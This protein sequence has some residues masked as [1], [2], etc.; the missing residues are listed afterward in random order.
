MQR[1][2]IESHEKHDG[3]WIETDPEGE[4][5]R[6]DEAI[7]FLNGAI[8]LLEAAKGSLPSD[9]IV[10]LRIREFLDVEAR[11]CR[12]IGSALRWA[13]EGLRMS[14]ETFYVVE[15]LRNDW[16][17]SEKTG[18]RVAALRAYETGLRYF[19]NLKWRLSE[20]RVV[21]SHEPR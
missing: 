11:S 10:Y 8:N 20:V 13:R 14:Q 7:E 19:G 5:V 15:F 16:Q 21:K 18:D 6:A 2:K 17:I 3:L 1:L 9:D 12:E 4:F